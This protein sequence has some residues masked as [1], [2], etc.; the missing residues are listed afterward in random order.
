MVE[1]PTIS[2]DAFAVMQ[3]DSWPGNV[4]ELENITCRLLL[5][6]RGLS[7]NA[8]AVRQTLAARDTEALPMVKSIAARAGDFLVHAQ[9]GELHDAPARML[10][11]AEREI[12]TQAI[13]LAEGNQARA[14]RWLGLSRFTLREKLKQL[15][16]HPGLSDHNSEPN[17]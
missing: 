14:A 11:E 10:A 17:A 13:T 4:R 3:A 16:L 15:G 7:I 2:A 8:E 1:N 12:L 9:K 6:A 5:A